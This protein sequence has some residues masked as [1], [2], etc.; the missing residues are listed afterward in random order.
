METRQVSKFQ[1]AADAIK[2]I[3]DGSCLMIGGFGGVGTPPLL[4][5]AL[6][7]SGVK[8]LTVICN[9]SGFPDIGIGR[10]IVN[11]RIKKLITSHIGSNPIAGKMMTEGLL[12]VEFNPQGTLAERIRAGGTGLG[13]ILT[14]VGIGNSMLEK[15]KQKV[16]IGEKEYLL[17][18]PLTAD[19]AF[20]KA[21]KAD[22][23]G[24][25][26]YSKT[27]RNMNPLMAMAGRYTIAEIDEYDEENGLNGEEIITPGIFVQAIVQSEGV[28][29]KWAWEQA[30]E[31]E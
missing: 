16:K 5:K 28:N 4:I 30:E 14:D 6:L 13:G 17:E 2:Q 20:I 19:A 23:Y 7:E 1:T 31:A 8:E 12:E 27:A 25:L 22:T 24:N 18:T 11:K 29:W 26:I 21:K 10:L 9:D 15:G 3:K